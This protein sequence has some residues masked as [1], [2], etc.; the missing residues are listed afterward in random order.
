MGLMLL[1]FQVIVTRK[2]PTLADNEYEVCLFL[3]QPIGIPDGS[4][5]FYETVSVYRCA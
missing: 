1:P 3:I 5:G 4:Y 2:A